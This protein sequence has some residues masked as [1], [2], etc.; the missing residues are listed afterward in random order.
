MKDNIKPLYIIAILIITTIAVF[1]SV[2]SSIDTKERFVIAVTEAHRSLI[3]DKTKLAAM[4]D[5]S[6]DIIVHSDESALAGSIRSGEADAYIVSP[7]YFISEFSR[8]ENA[9]AIFGI[10]SEY[11]LVSK[12]DAVNETNKV[13]VFEPYMSQIL[14][15]TEPLSPVTIYG[16]HDRIVAMDEAYV[17]HI[18]IHASYFDDQKYVIKDRMS[19]KGYT[20]DLFVLTSEWIDY[21]TENGHALTDALGSAMKMQPDKPIEEEL[22]R[23]MS[24]LFRLEDISTRYYYA[25]LVHSNE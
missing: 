20:Q 7:F 4:L 12:K 15:D 3:V 8:L 25:D 17:S 21:D 14:Q 11:Y 24:Y 1:F 5:R 9:K 13:A 6:V 23:T 19:A 16:T 18:I 10:E 22:L 2:K